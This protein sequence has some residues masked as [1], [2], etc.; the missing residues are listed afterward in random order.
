MTALQKTIH[1]FT[2][3]FVLLFSMTLILPAGQHLKLCIDKNKNYS[4]SLNTC[5]DHTRQ[6]L[7]LT[8][9][10]PAFDETEE[11]SEC[12]DL[13]LACS[14]KDPLNKS[15]GISYQQTV[16]K[17]KIFGSLAFLVLEYVTCLTDLHKQRIFYF[18]IQ[19]FPSYNLASLSTVVLCN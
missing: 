9:Y 19:N 2:L 3:T 12:L 5:I 4:I 14:A 8:N 13:P 15:N 11:H 10:L 1:A 17:K 7:D 6:T 18:P 16:A